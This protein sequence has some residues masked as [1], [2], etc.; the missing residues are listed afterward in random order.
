MRGIKKIIV[1]FCACVFIIQSLVACTAGRQQS[2]QGNDSVS[3]NNTL[4]ISNPGQNSWDYVSIGKYWYNDTNHDGKINP[5]D[6]AERIIWRVLSVEDRDKDGIDDTAL[7][8][9]EQ[10]VDELQF[11]AEKGSACV[12]KA[13]WENCTLRE[14]L[15][16]TFYNAAF[17]DEEKSEIIE[18]DISTEKYNGDTVETKDKVFLLSFED[19]QNERYGFKRFTKRDIENVEIKSGVLRVKGKT[20]VI[21]DSEKTPDVIVW[22]LRSPSKAQEGHEL[23]V[24]DDRISKYGSWVGCSHSVRPAM[25]VSL[26]HAEVLTKVSKSAMAR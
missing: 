21:G 15:N 26:N 4:D 1:S 2:D 16:N 11:D 3:V 7:L 17:N 20:V 18:T 6:E 13:D 12:E 22:W 8:L 9:T 5:N 24:S 14:W 10:C 23:E 19:V 25:Y